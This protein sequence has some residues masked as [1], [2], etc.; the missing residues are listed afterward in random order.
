M[1]MRRTVHGR[2]GWEYMISV[3]IIT[4]NEEK[5][6]ERCLASLSGY[7]FELVVVDTGSTDRTREIAQKHTDSVYDFAWCDDFSAA[8]NFGVSQAKNDMILVV[9]SDEFLDPLTETELKAFLE[10]V[11]RH[12]DSV[13]RVSRRNV[14][15]RDGV[16]QEN[17]EWINRIF[18][19]RKFRYKGRIHEQITE[20]KG[21]EYETW[22]SPLTFLH[23]GYD[24]SPKEREEKTTRNILL[25]KKELFS[26]QEELESLRREFA[27]A[28]AYAE[29]E[30]IGLE[31]I[32]AGEM[33]ELE[34]QIPYLLYQLGK[35]YYMAGDYQKSCGYFDRGLSYDLN[36]KLEYV[37]DMVESYGYALINSEQEEKALFFE[38]IYEEFGHSADFQFLMGLIYMKNA[39][40]DAAV[41][42]FEKALLHKECRNTGVNSYAA[43]YNIGVIHECLGDLEQARRY[44]LKCG[45]HELAKKRLMEINS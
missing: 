38:N 37:I 39:K 2:K 41:G 14:Y 5:N 34:G 33:E 15:S 3:C 4:K 36:P 12:S 27:D 24:L 10:L 20:R 35:S 25:L 29:R 21:E 17:R 31:N 16:R 18:D 45:E 7:G 9:D 6:I 1:G 22:L 23:T 40:F 19:R 8:K 13:G 43:N 11:R 44:Y 28:K 26:V 30:G 32:G 42:E